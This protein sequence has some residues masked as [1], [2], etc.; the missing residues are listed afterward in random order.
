MLF[1]MLFLPFAGA[2]S[3]RVGRRP[4]WRVSLI[5]LL[6]GVVPLYM[7]MGTGLAGATVAFVL[8]GLLYVP[9]LATIS[10]TFPALFPTPVRF[11]GFALAYNVSTSIFGGPA[12]AIG[13]ALIGWTGAQL[14]P[15]YYII[16][17]CLLG[18]PAPPL[19][20]Q[21]AGRSPGG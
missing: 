7:L 16:L 13:S 4:M 18:L 9:Q 14:M 15:A 6:V 11:A 17:A 8:L 1:M 20:P 19:L 21:P 3:D 12:P 5:G 10:A 2:L